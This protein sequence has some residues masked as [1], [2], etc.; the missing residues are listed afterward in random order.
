MCML[1]IQVYKAL[2]DGFKPVAV[3]FLHPASC[4]IDESNTAKFTKEIEL[5]RACR[6][7]NV[8]D[9]HG[10][11]IQKVQRPALTDTISAVA[12]DLLF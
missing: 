2:L 6:D 10:A 7:K 1:L 8:V 4:A 12:V 11:W 5:L 3:K 9:F